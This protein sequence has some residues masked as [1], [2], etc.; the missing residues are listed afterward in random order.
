[1][2]LGPLLPLLAAG[3]AGQPH[4]CPALSTIELSDAAPA[5]H[6][7]GGASWRRDGREAVVA[8]AGD[9]VYDASLVTPPFAVPAA[10]SELAFDHR[11]DLSWAST[12]A[13]LEISIDGA[14][15][16]DV[17]AA[18]G[19]FATGG[20]GHASYRSNPLGERA[21]WGGQ[22]AT[23]ATRVVLPRAAQGHAAR[24]RFR[25]GSGGTGDARAGWRVGPV[26]CLW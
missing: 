22:D 3:L 11:L 15:W 24:L 7:Q 10:R 17:V 18:G 6:A 1:M 16:R 13:V 23:L 5:W 26:R 20:Y 8:D 25:L 21:A 14:P 2:P 12:A 4:G 9:R 19:E